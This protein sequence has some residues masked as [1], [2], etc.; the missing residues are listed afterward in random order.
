MNSFDKNIDGS[1]VDNDMYLDTD[2]VAC[3]V[4][5]IVRFEAE[6]EVFTLFLF[7]PFP[8][9]LLFSISSSVCDPLFLFVAVNIVA[10]TVPDPE[11]LPLGKTG[12]SL[13][14]VTS[15]L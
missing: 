1:F 15:F 2:E 6:I 14:C 7:I 3:F 12:S 9:F 13:F 5:S 10:D 11:L 4:D 8:K